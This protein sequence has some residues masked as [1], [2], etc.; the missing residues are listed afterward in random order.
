MENKQYDL[1]FN[2]VGNQQASFADFTAVGLNVDNT[3]LQDIS[4]YRNDPY[5]R[6]QF[7]DDQGNFN[8]M[9][10]QSV[11]NQAQANYNVMA[12]NSYDDIMKS[13]LTF[14]RSNID[15]PYEARRKGPDFVEFKAPNPQRITSSV[16]RLGELGER[17]LSDDELAQSNRV[18]LNPTEVDKTGDWSKAQ[19]GDSPNDSF[20]QNFFETLVMAQWDSDG[21]H[22]DPITGETVKHQKG[23]LKL[24]DDGDYYYERLDGRDIYGHRVLNKMN[25]LT[26][27]GSQLNKYDFFDSDDINQK[28]IGGTVLKNLALVGS[29]FIPYVGPW[30]TGLSLATQ[31]AG[32]GATLGKMIV[33]SDS[34]TLSAIEGWSKSVSRQGAQTEYAQ[35][36]AWC[37]EN[38]INLIGDVAGQLKEQRFVFEKIPYV[39]KG[40]NMMSKE[41]QAA[42]LQQ[43]EQKQLKLANTKIAELTSKGVSGTQLLR[44]EQELK[45]VSAL[46]AQ[47]ELDSFIKGYNKLGEV[48]SKGYMTMITVGDTYGEAKAAGA[49]DL[50]A[51]LLTLGYAAGEY[52]ILNTGIGEWVLPELRA[53]RY[54]AQAIARALTQEVDQTA[55]QLRRQFGEQ[56]R[57]FSKEGKKEY[58]KK[59]FK[60]GRNIARAEYSNGTKTLTATSAAGLGEGVEEVSEELLAD[61]SKGCF[62]VVKWLQG[63]DTRLNAFGYNFETGQW[64]S[65]ELIDRYGMSL[66][67]GFV[68]GGLTNLGTNYKMV[69]SLGTM[70]H[71]QAIEQ[72]VYMSRNGETSQFLKEIERMQLRPKNLSATQT[73]EV[74]GRFMPAPG[75][76]EDN[77]DLFMKKAIRNQ[78]RLIDSILAANG[79]ALSDQS[80]LD[81]QTLKDLR[82]NALHQSATA[83]KYLQE[84]NSLASKLVVLTN[85]I[86]EVINSETD[87]NNDGVVTDREQ[88]RAKLSPDKQEAVKKL[89]KELD[90]TKKAIQDLIDGKRSS[91][92]IADALFEMTVALSGED[93]LA[94]FPLFAEKVEG[95]KFSEISDERKEVLRR[96]YEQWITSEGRDRIPILAGIYRNIAEQA[97]SVIKEQ[98]QTYIATDPEI[99]RING[100]IQQ[101]YP[102]LFSQVELDAQVEQ[103]N[104]NAPEGITIPSID[105]GEQLPQAQR[106]TTRATQAIAQDLLERLGMT[107]EDS[108]LFADIPNRI[109]RPAEDAT[110]EEVNQWNDTLDR[111]TRRVTMQIAGRRLA[112][113]IQP[114]LDRGFANAETKNQLNRLA[115]DAMNVYKELARAWDQEF[116][117]NQDPFNPSDEVNPYHPIVAQ[118]NDLRRQI[119]ELDNT[120]L[121]QNLDQFSMSIGQDPI[122]L[123]AL[124]DRLNLAFNN[125]SQDITQFN[126]DDTLY[127]DLNGAIST[128]KLYKQAILGARTDATD[129]GNLYGYNATLNEVSA[130]VGDA[131]NLAEINSSVADLF[132]ADIDTNLKKLEF[133]KK[134][135]E[136][137]QGQKLAKQDRVSIKK[138]LL[139]YK[140]LKSIV[141][142]L[143]DDDELNRWEGFLD[144]QNIVNGMALHQDS[145]QRNNLV[146][147]QNE[148]LKFEEEK[149]RLEDGVYDFFQK[150]ADKLKDP[151]LLKQF[152]NPGRLSLY[153]RATELLNEG[154]EDL[155]DNSLVWWMASRAAVK[156]SD[157]YGQYR[158]IID[159]K[160]E[161]PLAPISTQELAIY[162]NYAGVVNGDAFT[163][164]YNAYRQSV[165]EDWARKSVAERAEIIKRLDPSKTEADINLLSSDE[166][167]DQVLN[168][169]A[170]PKY[171]NVVF[172][173]GIPG[174]GKSTG[175]FQST[176][177]MLKAYHPELLSNVAVIHGA[178]PD[179]AT[180]LRD[181]IGLDNTN[182]KTYGRTEWMKEVSPTWKERTA[183][184][185]GVVRIPKNE[186]TLTEENEIRSALGIKETSTPPS[187]IVI[188]EISKFSGFDLDLIDKFARKYGITILAAGDFDQ[189][190]VVGR[191]KVDIKGHSDLGWDVSLDR[192]QFI[193]SPKLGV[194]MRT[195][196]QLKTANLQKLQA[197]LQNPSQGVTFNYYQDN[198]GLYGDKV[199]MFES[200]EDGTTDKAVQ[201]DSIIQDV[202]NMIATL[203]PGEKIGY[204]YSDKAS[205]I[206]QRLFQDYQDH[207]DFR[208]GGSAQGL[209][210]QYYIVEVGLNSDESVY[211]REVYTGMSRAQQGSLLIVPS[212]MDEGAAI[213][214]KPVS[215][216]PIGEGLKKNVISQFAEKRKKLLD[217]LI[218]EPQ[219]VPY[220][221]RAK[222]ED[223]NNQ[224]QTPPPPTGDQA[225]L[226]NGIDP[227]P[228][229]SNPD[230]EPTPTPPPLTPPSN[231]AEPITPPEGA[232]PLTREEVLSRFDDRSKIDTFDI[233]IDGVTIPLRLDQIPFVNIKDET[234]TNNIVNFNK[235]HIVLVNINGFHL[236]FY[237]STGEAG[238]KNVPPGHW[239]PIFGISQYGWLN[240]GTEEQIANYYD[241][242]VFRA[243]SEK[244]DELMGTDP[245]Q[246]QIFGPWYMSDKDEDVSTLPQ[247]QFIN[248]DM[249]PVNNKT[250]ITI[251]TVEQNIADAKKMAEG[252][253]EELK[254]QIA[255]IQDDTPTVEP[256]FYEQNDAPIVV[257]TDVINETEYKEKINESNN[258]EV[259]PESTVQQ[260]Q[261]DEVPIAIEMLLH[262]FN[263]FEIGV[264]KG[265]NGEIIRN[266][267][268]DRIDSVNGLIKIDQIKGVD[269][270]TKTLQKYIE[271]IGRLRSIIY[272]TPDKSQLCQKLQKE[273]G[274]Q[275][276]YCTFALKSSPFSGDKNRQN[277]REFVE[278]QPTRFGKGI[279][280]RLEFNYSRDF[281]SQEVPHKSLVMIIGNQQNGDV[282]ELPILTLSSPFTLLKIHRD[283][284]SVFS[285]MLHRYEQLSRQKIPMHEIS[286]TL[287]QEFRGN[288]KY[289]ELVDLFE[290]FN[291]TDRNIFYIKGKG[292]RDTDWTPAKDLQL[293]GPQ[294]VTKAGYYQDVAGFNYEADMTSEENWITIEHL[295]RENPQVKVLSKVAISKTGRISGISQPVVKAGN[296][297]VLIS[298]NRELDTDRKIVD[299]FIKQQKDP[300]ARKEV[301]LMY[302]LPPKAS[303]SDYIQNLH[304]I[305]SEKGVGAQSIGHLFTSYNLLRILTRDNQFRNRMEQ[306]HPRL[307]AKIDQ[308][309]QQLEALPDNA[310]RK[311]M[312]YDP[313]SWVSE[314]VSAKPVRLGGLLDGALHDFVYSKNTLN[315]S[316][317]LAN[318]NQLDPD[319]LKLVEDILTQSGIDGVFYTASLPKTGADKVTD[320]FLAPS[321]ESG[322]Q[323]NGMPYRIHG[324]ID[325]YTF[326]GH[327]G[328]FISS[329]LSRMST[330]T[331]RT[332]EEHIVC[333]DNYRYM[334]GR[335]NLA[336]FYSNTPAN[337]NDS[338]IS[339]NV[340]YVT[341]KLGAEIGSTLQQMYDS[342]Q[343]SDQDIIEANKNLARNIN[344]QNNG[345]VAFAIGKELRI[346]NKND[347]LNGQ[348][349]IQDHSGN[350]IGLDLTNLANNNGVYSFEIKVIGPQGMT[351]YMV[352]YNG[353]EMQLVPKQLETQAPKTGLSVTQENFA[354]YLTTAKSLVPLLPRAEVPLRKIFESTQ[355]YEELIASMEALKFT[356]KR[357][358]RLQALLEQNLTPEQIA[359]VNELIEFESSRDPFK[360]NQDETN[361]ICPI[362]ITIKF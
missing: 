65:S 221:A 120:P 235:R 210:G 60:I 23:E 58:V 268:E 161:K 250:S 138:D 74:D 352:E 223:S 115:V 33:G 171:Q 327:M 340:A 199:H 259:I 282:L 108:Q 315:Q 256:L 313:Q 361:Q 149:I 314:G 123:T 31:L 132:V 263:T 26:T 77:Q 316:A 181:D 156:A 9:R 182:S 222:E 146:L 325:S 121:E 16:V 332:G 172:T 46:K 35:Q 12:N 152:I 165:K 155:D 170:V 215:S 102:E 228:P 234:G 255:P 79:A 27:D 254:R 300:L 264:L 321:Q 118:I 47:A 148:R 117:E 299:Q 203:N 180:S 296:P 196:N 311:D 56:L 192:T 48:L 322:Y 323:I 355:T 175:V 124:I 326:K 136:I 57:S 232:T 143:G 331:A 357:V 328:G 21:E 211:L 344:V 37:W 160:A 283:G 214:S 101:L 32:V 287:V 247:I 280:E 42:K 290:L 130:K 20:F 38:F 174:S 153:T 159:P 84:Y 145:L 34:P 69:N 129:L 348:V 131:T 309:I 269:P 275:G 308:A 356:D 270:K 351:E 103:M 191:A 253:V 304:K 345:V 36:N 106:M 90:D 169:I 150:N 349:F 80:F 193:R 306:K 346:S 236:P 271:Q 122:T 39:F 72:L 284:Q 245:T 347:I 107:Q 81:A 302:V 285:E 212:N 24:N 3:S 110:V 177:K 7:T 218:T 277:G 11:Y 244:L 190:G 86:D 13:Q 128:L 5:I 112:S 307:L 85:Q 292:G 229:P 360:Q 91:E 59:L 207:I 135:F 334:A 176:L 281:R 297:F 262:S 8:E 51:T 168:I 237:K 224:T 204:I 109:A 73:R 30:I 278:E 294:F 336:S 301:K 89:E 276:I 186:V 288:T 61:F 320:H 201:L 319:D 88:R 167:A 94:S 55:A 40:A 337:P 208:E 67:G 354:A 43:L 53:G 178:N 173:E 198:T 219:A 126:I 330:I 50:D 343:K 303:I 243:I 158:Q 70:N 213:E 260:S 298:F 286:Q 179:S 350:S 75:T 265:P 241:S 197:Y 305:I 10:F 227:T 19:W 28:S 242:P 139:V 258:E 252:M 310:A 22:I 209:E 189:S 217:S 82:F 335:S 127:K 329:V 216:K 312:L 291:L 119:N 113:Y 137:N 114:F 116:E 157:F 341:Q 166:F 41:G 151:N 98:E 162:N 52:A 324:K 220:V 29:M 205:P 83:G 251:D 358:P 257:G 111:E 342:T 195:D 202:E 17:T 293:M 142:V 230:P 267:S 279:S 68:G 95:K 249:N 353:T 62:D 2:M 154:L 317:G 183:D 238:K 71:K 78:V 194:S 272:N 100:L 133:L 64:D 96:S 141:Q 76:K 44:A 6:E 261:S 140:R 339:N 164:F 147:S 200:Y 163:A 266:G 87:T 225:S 362:T 4:V 1:M 187:L 274:I 134:L 63:E 185:T 188:D 144:L 93:T 66:V 125:V 295:R 338:V 54:R 318:S 206:Y 289:K 226:D 184:E 18:L 248:Q 359:L 273:L 15:V 45:A 104:A 246:N 231:P 233:E 240:K 333:S 239:Y 97:S 25:I 99:S 92:F 49:S 14:H 105:A